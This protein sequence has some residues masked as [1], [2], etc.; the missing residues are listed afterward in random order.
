MHSTGF[1]VSPKPSSPPVYT[2]ESVDDEEIREAIE[3]VCSFPF[4]SSLFVCCLKALPA[5]ESIMSYY[6]PLEA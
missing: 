5:F 3:K 1:Q 2:L 6:L 4:F